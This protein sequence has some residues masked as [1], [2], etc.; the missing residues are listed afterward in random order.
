VVSRTGCRWGFAL[1]DARELLLATHVGGEPLS[2]V[3]DA[4]VRLLAPS[5]RG[6]QWV[7]WVER[8]D[9]LEHPDYG[10]PASTLWSSFTRAGRGEA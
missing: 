10:A 4:P 8:I 1:A 6:F 5:A 7:K 2:H 9:L 3:H